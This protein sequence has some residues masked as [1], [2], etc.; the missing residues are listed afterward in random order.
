M[1]QFT[2]YLVPK[3]SKMAIAE[4]LTTKKERFTIFEDGHIIMSKGKFEPSKANIFDIQDKPKRPEEGPVDLV[5]HNIWGEEIYR[6]NAELRRWRIKCEKIDEI[7]AIAHRQQE[8]EFKKHLIAV[9]KRYYLQEKLR[10]KEEKER[11]KSLDS[12]RKLAARAYLEKLFQR[13]SA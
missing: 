1:V 13:E 10:K 11:R 7:N 12:R 3:E 6:E 9:R 8:K 2:P 4:I 5:E